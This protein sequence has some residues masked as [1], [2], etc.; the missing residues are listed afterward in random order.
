VDLLAEFV[1]GKHLPLRAGFENGDLA[2]GIRKEY[3]AVRGNR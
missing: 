3:L 1:D 2:L